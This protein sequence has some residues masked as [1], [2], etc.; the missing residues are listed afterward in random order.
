MI[1]T[2]IQE[3]WW[4]PGNTQ[5]WGEIDFSQLTYLDSGS[6]SYIY[7]DPRSEYLYKLYFNW[8][9]LSCIQAY[10]GRQSAA[11]KVLSNSSY[12]RSPAPLDHAWNKILIGGKEVRS[13]VLNILSLDKSTIFTGRINWEQGIRVFSKNR[14]I[15]WRNC[16]EMIA[17]WERRSLWWGKNH[18]NGV[19]IIV[20]Y[21][22][23]VLRILGIAIGDWH[24]THD[25]EFGLNSRNIKITDV[26][27]SWELFLTVTDLWSS[28]VRS[29]QGHY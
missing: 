24:I 7:L 14:Y 22:R 10:H 21:V 18:M 12:L 27:D 17:E 26:S 20:A 25:W 3:Y 11:A 1:I 9:T 13:I 29:M 16:E 19:S 28:I 2:N 5:L 15:E 6:D 23:D 4:N 8:I